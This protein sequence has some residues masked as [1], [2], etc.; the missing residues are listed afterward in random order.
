[1]QQI[2]DFWNRKRLDEMTRKEWESLC[3]GCA[4]C[5][6]Y[7][8]EDQDTREVWFTNVVC[9]L[10]DLESCRC[11]DYENRSVRMP[12]CVTLTPEKSRELYWMPR[13][14]AYRLLS[15]GKPLPHWHPLISGDPMTLTR[16]GNSIRGKVIPHCKADDL[17][18]HLITWIR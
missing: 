6:L 13:T 8:L 17:E 2:D 10:L 16:S 1:M 9:D 7:K 5:C 4:K 15:E 18:N 3:D 14:C 11:N 12:N